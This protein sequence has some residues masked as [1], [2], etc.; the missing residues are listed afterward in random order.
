MNRSSS[1][2]ILIRS[3]VKLTKQAMIH[4]PKIRSSSAAQVWFCDLPTAQL[5][6]QI[7]ITS[8]LKYKC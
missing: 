8:D 4:S 2:C 6:G 3:Q 5:N 1:K 7:V